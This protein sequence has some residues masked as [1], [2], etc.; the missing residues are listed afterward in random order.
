MLEEL[1]VKIV[2]A[3]GETGDL[4]A[5]LARYVIPTALARTALLLAG[6]AAVGGG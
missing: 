3:F 4:W 5:H 6:V 1:S 2:I